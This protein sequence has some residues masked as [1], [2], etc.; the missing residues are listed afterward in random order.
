[1]HHSC[2]FAFLNEPPKA[3]QQWVSHQILESE[4]VKAKLLSL[5]RLSCLY[6]SLIE[7][8][9][10]TIDVQ[11][12]SGYSREE[13]LKAEN[14][15]SFAKLNCIRTCEGSQSEVDNQF[16]ASHNFPFLLELFPAACR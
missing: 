14:Y 7:A 15:R 5:L 6:T 4:P 9:G 3:K 13:P 1:M 2:I 10:D 8:P 11:P 16:L 12:Q